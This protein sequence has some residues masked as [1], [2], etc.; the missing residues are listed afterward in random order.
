[1][2]WLDDK[3]NIDSYVVVDDYILDDGWKI[4]LDPRRF[5]IEEAIPLMRSGRW[6]RPADTDVSWFSYSNTDGWVYKNSWGKTTKLTS[7][8]IVSSWI[9]RKWEMQP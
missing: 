3:C 5:S 8:N 9:D 6:M 2:R 7:I 1:M 4:V